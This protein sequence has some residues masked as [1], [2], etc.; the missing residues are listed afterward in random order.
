MS[1]LPTFYPQ[2]L[3][4][5]LILVSKALARLRAAGRKSADATRASG[6]ES[7]KSGSAAAVKPAAA[8]PVPMRGVT[9]TKTRSGTRKSATTGAAA[10]VAAGPAPRPPGPTRDLTLRILAA[11]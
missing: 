1:E 9:A 5:V 7:R 10:T 11:A 3:T 6:K 8:V 4:T 2:K